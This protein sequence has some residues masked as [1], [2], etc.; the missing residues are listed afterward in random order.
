MLHIYDSD[1][2]I[3]EIDL[4]TRKKVSE[5]AFQN[6]LLT[7]KKQ[8]LGML[9]TCFQRNLGYLVDEKEK[10]LESLTEYQK[11][12]V[13]E[14]DEFI[15]MT[16]RTNSVEND[17]NLKIKILGNK[18]ESTNKDIIHETEKEN[19]LR[20]KR[21]RAQFCSRLKSEIDFLR[22]FYEEKMDE[23]N[24]EFEARY[25][26]KIYDINT[27]IQE[28]Y[29]NKMKSKDVHIAAL[30]KQNESYR[31]QFEE[32]TEK[33]HLENP[34]IMVYKTLICS[35]IDGLKRFK[36]EESRPDLSS[37]SRRSYISRSSLIARSRSHSSSRKISETT[38]LSTRSTSR[39]SFSSN[40]Y[41]QSSSNSSS[42]T[43]S[44]SRKVSHSE[45]F[46]SLRSNDEESGSKVQSS[47]LSV[48]QKLKESL[49]NIEQ[50]RNIVRKT[51]FMG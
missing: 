10:V 16:K 7:S 49:E 18:L 22:H 25:E 33:F 21:F 46:P 35:E 3:A 13:D 30:I 19:V 2:K 47:L 24:E 48:H 38:R 11:K 39:S 37:S 23:I 45:S 26:K 29:F 32:I 42:R 41:S 14:E 43:S 20:N 1:K 17:L 50:N 31:K 28:N 5:F 51:S 4:E 44:I 36:T 34:E 40:S 27:D 9:K 6:W 12:L 15:E 8:E